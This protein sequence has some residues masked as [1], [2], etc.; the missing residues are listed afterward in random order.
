M[1]NVVLFWSCYI[2]GSIQKSNK[3]SPPISQL[4]LFL[5]FLIKIYL[6]VFWLCWV[7][8]AEWVLPYLQ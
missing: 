8:V 7:L 4:I 5:I 3:I 6:F 2:H 1:V